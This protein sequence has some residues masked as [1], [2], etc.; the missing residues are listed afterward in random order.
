MRFGC[1][2]PRPQKRNL[3]HPQFNED[4]LIDKIDLGG[5]G[6]DAALVA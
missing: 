1:E 2:N 6:D 3:E 5:D 4:A